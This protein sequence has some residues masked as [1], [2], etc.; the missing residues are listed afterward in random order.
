[1]NEKR[2]DRRLLCAELVQVSF[3]SESAGR[4]HIVANME[5]ISSAGLCLQSETRI[6]DGT[7]VTVNYGQG[8]FVGIVRYCVFREIG[9]LI[10]IEFDGDCR[11]S[12]KNFRPEHLLDPTRISG[13][14]IH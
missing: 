9:Y 10:G 6:P 12:E 2:R 7:E 14:T 4:Q 1:M 11:W 3:R 5:D 8:E 13:P